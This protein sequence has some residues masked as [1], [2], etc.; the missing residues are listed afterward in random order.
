MLLGPH[1]LTKIA[2]V[3]ALLLPCH[4]FQPIFCF[5]YVLCQSYLP[6]ESN[7]LRTGL[8]LIP[9]DRRVHSIHTRPST[10]ISLVTSIWTTTGHWLV[11]MIDFELAICITRIGSRMA[12]I[13]ELHPLST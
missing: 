3:S 12:G 1:A 5:T 9:T 13:E 10:L 4:P 6:Y 11:L 7:V 2:P 8:E